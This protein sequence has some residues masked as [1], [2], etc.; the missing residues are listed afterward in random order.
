MHLATGRLIANGAFS[1][2]ADP[3]T[4]TAQGVWVNHNW[5][6]DLVSYFLYSAESS[7]VLLVVVKAL[8]ATADRAVTAAD[9]WRC[10]AT[11]SS[12]RARSALNWALWA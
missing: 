10:W 4:F 9:M 7:G 2:G 11:A 5:L 8:L 1:F 3:F 12:I 6:S